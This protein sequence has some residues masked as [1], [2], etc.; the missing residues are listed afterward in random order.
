V[1]Y[2]GSGVYHSS[3]D[4]CYLYNLTGGV[5]TDP[6]GSVVVVKPTGNKIWFQAKGFFVTTAAA[7]IISITV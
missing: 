2:P 6:K 3:D 4:Y 7:N 5:G 1:L